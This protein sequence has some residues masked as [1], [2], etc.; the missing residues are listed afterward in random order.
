[1]L[2]SI[3]VDFVWIFTVY[4][5]KS[6]RLGVFSLQRAKEAFHSFPDLTKIR[7]SYKAC[8]YLCWLDTPHFRIFNPVQVYRL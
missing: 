4:M 1:M 7:Y 2:L 3:M 8:A 5:F 6:T